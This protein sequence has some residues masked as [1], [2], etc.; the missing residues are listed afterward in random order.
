M[1]MMHEVCINVYACQ[2]NNL[3]QVIMSVNALNP[4]PQ[5]TAF[6]KVSMSQ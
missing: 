6:Q 5:C 3:L 1:S 2:W 4:I